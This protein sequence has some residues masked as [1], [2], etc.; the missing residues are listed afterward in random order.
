MKDLTRICMTLFYAVTLA[1]ADS[2][3]KHKG[4][5]ISNLKPDLL[6]LVV[7]VL[8]N[9]TRS[10]LERLDVDNNTEIADESEDVQR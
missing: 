7:N 6:Y 3:R 9:T 2:I 4:I 10:M 1:T 5:F 8:S